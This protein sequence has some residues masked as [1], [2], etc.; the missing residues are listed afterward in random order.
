MKVLAYVIAFPV[1]L[2]LA[3]LLVLY[4]AL[5]LSCIWDWFL[6]GQ[7][8]P[9]PLSVWLGVTLLLATMVPYIHRSEEAM[10]KA[11]TWELCQPAVVWA[12]AWVVWRVMLEV[13][14]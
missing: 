13:R 12:A 1:Y 8:G 6:A 10:W 7:F 9:L 5:V 11:M 3:P 14:G 2:V 4:N